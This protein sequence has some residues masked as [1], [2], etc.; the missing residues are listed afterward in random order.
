MS[1]GRVALPGM[2]H[3]HEDLSAL[4]SHPGWDRVRDH[5]PLLAK[6]RNGGGE[7]D[8]ASMSKEEVRGR[9]RGKLGRTKLY[10]SS[11]SPIHI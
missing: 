7:R 6:Q 2:F 4:Q 10:R 1:L 5:G 3:E 11:S 9:I 8:Q